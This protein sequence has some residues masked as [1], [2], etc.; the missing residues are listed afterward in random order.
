M[1]TQ[2]CSVCVDQQM[3]MYQLCLEVSAIVVVLYCEYS[4]K[5]CVFL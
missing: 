2:Q 1:I 3:G 4:V 5:V